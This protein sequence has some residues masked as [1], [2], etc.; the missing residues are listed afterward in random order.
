MKHYLKIIYDANEDEILYD[1]KEL[2]P[3]C[4]FGSGNPIDGYGK[5]KVEERPSLQIVHVKYWSRDVGRY[6]WS[7]RKYWESA[8]DYR[9]EKKD[10]K[11]LHKLLKVWFPNCEFRY[12]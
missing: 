12:S 4:W 3:T 10:R 9:I 8:G 2:T 1:Y 6:T 5:W 7:G 11:Q